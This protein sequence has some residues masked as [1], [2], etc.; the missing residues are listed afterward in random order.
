MTRPDW[1]KL[2][3][4]FTNH[5][6]YFIGGPNIGKLDSHFVWGKFYL[7]GS[8]L[9]EIQDIK[10]PY[11]TEFNIDIFILDKLSSHPVIRKLDIIVANIL[12]SCASSLLLFKY[13][14][15]ILA[16]MMSKSLKN[17]FYFNLRRLYGMIVAWIP[18]R[19]WV[20]WHDKWI[21][22]HSK[23]IKELET[24]RKVRYFIKDY[25]EDVFL[26]FT[27]GVFRNHLFPLPN[28]IDKYLKL[29]YG[30]NYMNIPPVENRETHL[31]HK[32]SFPKE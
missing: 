8:E 2:K 29:T 18:H 24:T 23:K 17:K 12:R 20:N 27:N 10:T 16:Q 21:S 22:R 11:P 13:N 26:P 31:I 1:E 25:D 4:N 9:I 14:N 32:I 7:K 5:P 3:C 19:S 28:K 30:V 6:K 15:K